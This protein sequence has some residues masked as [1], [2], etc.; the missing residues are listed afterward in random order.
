M[1]RW[2]VQL[3]SGWSQLTH[4]VLWVKAKLSQFFRDMYFIIRL[5]SL[6]IIIYRLLADANLKNDRS[7]HLESPQCSTGSSVQQFL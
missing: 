3:E 1:L 4:Q 7:R 2:L 6:L 5:L